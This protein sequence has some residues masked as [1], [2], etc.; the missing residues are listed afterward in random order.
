[1]ESYDPCTCPYSATRSS[2]ASV[3]TSTTHS[4]E[5]AGAFDLCCWVFRGTVEEVFLGRVRGSRSDP[6]QTFDH[7]QV[8]SCQLIL[9]TWPS[10]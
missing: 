2:V 10:S 4:F 1:M 6:H 7:A 9:A 8:D 5:T 3:G